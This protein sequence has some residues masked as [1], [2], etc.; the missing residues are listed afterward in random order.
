[1]VKGRLPYKSNGSPQLEVLSSSRSLATRLLCSRLC[2]PLDGT[3]KPTAALS[4]RLC[5][6]ILAGIMLADPNVAGR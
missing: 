5:R 6:S 2:N 4:G 1:M 3:G